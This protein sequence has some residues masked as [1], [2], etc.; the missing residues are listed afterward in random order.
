M[1]DDATL[2]ARFKHTISCRVDFSASEDDGEWYDLDVY[3]DSDDPKTALNGYLDAQY[4]EDVERGGKG[5]EVKV[6]DPAFDD[7]TVT[8]FYRLK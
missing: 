8:R 4:G 7:Q 2:Y 6:I 5:G 1:K 3:S